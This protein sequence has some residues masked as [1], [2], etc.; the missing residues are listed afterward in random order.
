MVKFWHE[1]LYILDY[2]N[3]I[4][5]VL[6]KWVVYAGTENVMFINIVDLSFMYLMSNFFNDLVLIWGKKVAEDT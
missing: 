6:Q 5:V 4:C 2:I 3:Q 1:K